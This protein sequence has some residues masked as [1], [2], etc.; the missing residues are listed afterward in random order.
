MP[1]ILFEVFVGV[2]S[3]ASF[4]ERIDSANRDNGMA[5]AVQYIPAPPHSVLSNSL[6]TLTAAPGRGLFFWGIFSHR[7][8]D[9]TRSWQVCCDFSARRQNRAAN[10]LAN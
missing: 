2:K 10:S 7:P 5:A 1:T 6:L 8:N 4:I 3:I 9:R